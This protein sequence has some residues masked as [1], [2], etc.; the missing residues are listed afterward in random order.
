MYSISYTKHIDKVKTCYHLNVEIKSFLSLM[1]E[2]PDKNTNP[3]PIR[4][5]IEIVAKK[6]DPNISDSKIRPIPHKN[7]KIEENAEK[8]RPKIAEIS[9]ISFACHI[10]LPPVSDSKNGSGTIP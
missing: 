4:P 1:E 10:I 7:G 8:T 3:L 9:T 5:R 6:A 2:I